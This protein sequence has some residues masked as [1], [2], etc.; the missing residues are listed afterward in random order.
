VIAKSSAQQHHDWISSVA[1]SGGHHKRQA[2]H[3][4]NVFDGEAAAKLDGRQN[5]LPPNQ[6]L[7][8]GMAAAALPPVP[9]RGAGAA[10]SAAVLTPRGHRRSNSYGHH[11]ALTGTNSLGGGGAASR[12][13][14]HHRR[15]GSSV[16]ET[17]QTLACTG[18]DCGREESLAQFLENLRREQAERFEKQ[19]LHEM[20]EELE[21]VRDC[22]LGSCRPRALQGLANIKVRRQRARQRE[23]QRRSSLQMTRGR[24]FLTAEKRN[25]KKG[26]MRIGPFFCSRM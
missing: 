5:S 9:G 16:V 12:L 10:A 25:W 24:G 2:S 22:G 17:L 26:Q 20:Q 15:T 21:D 7:A 6:S 8:K 23:R 4:G 14:Q 13:S 11:R 3:P 1:S 18:Q 19:E